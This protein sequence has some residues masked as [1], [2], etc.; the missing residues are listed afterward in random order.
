[1]VINLNL[2]KMNKTLKL[3]MVQQVTCH[4]QKMQT[5]KLVTS[6]MYINIS[7]R[8]LNDNCKMVKF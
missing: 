4:H 3:N 1:M 6:A 2:R 7:V 8:K 5:T